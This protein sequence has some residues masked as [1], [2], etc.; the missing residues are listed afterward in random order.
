MVAARESGQTTGITWALDAG[1]EPAEAAGGAGGRACAGAAGWAHARG[2]IAVA[3][4]RKSLVWMRQFNMGVAPPRLAYARSAP[5]RKR[6]A[7]F[8]ARTSSPPPMPGS[9][10]PSRPLIEAV[11]AGVIVPDGAMGTQLY[12]R[13]VLYSACFEELNASRPELVAKVHEDYLRAGAQVIETNTSGA[14]AL[15]LEKYGLQTRVRELNAAGV[16]IA[17]AAAAGQAYVAGAIGPSGYFLGQPGPGDAAGASAD[18][19]AKGKA[20]FSEQAKALLEAGVAAL[21]VETIRQ[22][23]ELR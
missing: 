20:V 14:N 22:T 12:E 10:R 5:L 18:D 15:R 7:H 2:K 1:E 8:L 16:R 17:R 13:G 6:A 11:R 23:P 19:L 4:T 21:I 9:F 3:T